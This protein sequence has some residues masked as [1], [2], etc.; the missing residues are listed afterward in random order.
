MGTAV[1][2]PMPDRVK[3]SFVIFDIRM[4]EI[5]NDGLTHMTTAGIKGLNGVIYCS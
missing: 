4:S 5:T 3:P 2:Q 1:K